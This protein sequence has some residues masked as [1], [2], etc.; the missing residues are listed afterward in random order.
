MSSTRKHKAREKRSRQSDVRANMEIMNIMLG[1]FTAGD[2][3]RQEVVGE[4]EVDLESN[5][6]HT[7]SSMTSKSY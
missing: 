6:L 3:G 4:L 2:F 5:G 7:M 1:N